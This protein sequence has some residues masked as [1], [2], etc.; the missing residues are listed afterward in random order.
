MINST[1]TRCCMETVRGAS[2]ISALTVSII[3]I[4]IEFGS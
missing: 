4:R 2:L 1:L 3:R